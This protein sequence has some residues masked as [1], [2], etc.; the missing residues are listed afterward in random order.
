MGVQANGQSAQQVFGRNRVQYSFLDW[1]F[2]SSNNFDIYFHQGGESMAREAI[3][4]SEREFSRITETIGYSPYNRIR[5]YLY[6]SPSRLAESNVGLE[7]S[8]SILGGKTSFIKNIVEVAHPGTQQELQ[9]QLSKGISKAMIY[10]M[11]YGGSFTEAVQSSYLMMLPEWFVEGVILYITEGASVQMDNLVRGDGLARDLKRPLSAKGER[12]AVIGQSIWAFIA[13]RYGRPSVS[14]ILNLT[15]IIRN[16]ENAM[17]STLGVPFQRLIRDWRNA[18]Y[19]GAES[20]LGDYQEPREETIIKK[21]KLKRGNISSLELSPDG[22][23]LAFTY[24]RQGRVHFD[25]LDMATNRTNHIWQYGERKADDRVTTHVPIAWA[26]NNALILYRQRKG[27]SELKYFSLGPK[28]FFGLRP[29]I[30]QTK[31]LENIDLVTSLASS[32]DGKVV[33]I[34]ATKDGQNDLYRITSNGSGLK[35]L[36]NDLADDIH[37]VVSPKGTSVF[38]ASN[39]PRDSAQQRLWQKGAYPSFAIYKANLADAKPKKDLII[40]GAYN[41][42]KPQFLKGGKLLVLSDASGIQNLAEVNADTTISSIT[43]Y[44]TGLM[45]F[46]YSASADVGVGFVYYNGR[47]TFIRLDSLTQKPALVLE[48]TKWRETHMQIPEGSFVQRKAMGSKPLASV[49]SSPS[50]VPLQDSLGAKPAMAS[51]VP[52]QKLGDSALIDIRNYVFEIEKKGFIDKQRALAAKEA[53]AANKATTQQAITQES[54]RRVLQQRESVAPQIVVSEPESYKNRLST[55]SV[56]TT[57]TVDPLRGWG[58]LME[59]GLTDMF[60][61]HR[62]RAKALPFLDLSSNM[63]SFQYEYLKRRIDYSFTFTKNA[64][65]FPSRES[66]LGTKNFLFKYEGSASYP[67]NESMRVAAIPFVAVT[68]Y[69]VLGN[70]STGGVI[71][72]RKRSYTGLRGEFVFDNSATSSN[73]VVTGSKAR[74]M[75]EYYQSIRKKDRTFGL[76]HADLRRYQ[77]IHREIT[78]AV[79]LSA[80]HYFGPGKKKYI[81]GGMDNWLFQQVQDNTA[82]GLVPNSDDPIFGSS[83]LYAREGYTDLLLNPF[84]TNLRGFNYNAMYGNTYGLLN[85]EIRMPIVKYLYKGPITSNFLRNLQFVG[86]YDVGS[87]WSGPPIWSRNSTIN[88]V[89]IVNPPIAVTVKTFR[90]PFLSGFGVGARTMILGYFAKLDLAWGQQNGITSSEPKF[91]LTL[92]HD[93]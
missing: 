21:L 80:G 23:K 15:R 57:F 18:Q 84:V 10:D 14:N 35:A 81:L 69:V 67:I 22:A 55:G 34:S 48:D 63:V 29:S 8:G 65:S 66:A 46:T 47:N 54:K 50:S 43:N 64:L 53:E 4:I 52:D 32:D 42:T 88:R 38:Y 44:A 16:E 39:S 62:F 86:F 28:T 9:L 83:E 13:E 90:N 12:G 60:D 85:V 56:T 79:R 72:D 73:N 92:G 68:N 30:V 59:V 1:K 11:M 40:A 20:V 78:L 71:Q 25:V 17:S 61:N 36:T 45:Q 75:S 58:L 31:V 3:K 87:A 77:T 19:S 27:K 41:Y 37:P 93:F 24:Q 51:P 7:A 74:V 5:I 82:N 6:D 70:A 89:T 2:I 76:I 91:Y 33:V 49:P 26:G